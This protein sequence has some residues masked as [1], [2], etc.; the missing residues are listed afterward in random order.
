MSI[1]TKGKN[2][3]SVGGREYLWHVHKEYELR[4]CSID[5]K[6]IVNYDLSNQLDDFAPLTI[7]GPEFS[8]VAPNR[9]LVVKCPNL[10]V[11][12]VSTPSGVKALLEWCQSAV[13][14]QVLAEE[15]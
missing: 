13:R 5:R 14:K 15:K 4:V 3:I 2:R 8:G 1:S 10:K 7:V 11:D 6:F 9:H 12:N